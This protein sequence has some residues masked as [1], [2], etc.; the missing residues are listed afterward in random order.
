MN[1]RATLLDHAETAIRQRGYTGFS[2]ADLAKTVGI[3]KASIHHHFPTKAALGLSLIERYAARFF[4]RLYDIAVAQSA[5]ADQLRAYIDL[6]REAL[7]RGEQVCL[8]V[9]LSAGR[10]HLSDDILVQLEEFHARSITWL[11]R[12]FS[13]AQDDG[14]VKGLSDPNAEAHALLALVEG[15]QLLARASKTPALF[16]HATAAFAGR[17]H[18]ETPR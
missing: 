3:R 5:A 18:S 13:Q 10:D 16:E 14:S 7:A 12:A 17:L 1:T 2:Y 15:A 9:A 4:E 11:E 6:Y 8:C